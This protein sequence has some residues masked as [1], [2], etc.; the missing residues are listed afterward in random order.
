MDDFQS[1]ASIESYRKAY[2]R[3]TQKLHGS[4]G[5]VYVYEEDGVRTLKVGSRNRWLV[6]GD[7]NYGFCSFVESQREAF[8]KM[9]LGRHYGEW[10]GP[11]INSGE[12]LKGKSFYLFSNPGRYIEGIP[13]S[14]GFVPEIYLGPLDSS[15]IEA[16]MQLLKEHGSRLVPGFMKPEGI[17]VDVCGVKL[18]KVFEAEETGWCAKQDKPSR[19]RKDYSYL[20][21]PIRLE[22]L[23]SRDESYKRDYPK[24]LPNI[25]RAYIDDLVKEEQIVGSLDEVE[26]I[27]K[28]A[29]RQIFQFIK[30][31]IL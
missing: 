17:V 21:Q 13:E 8:L 12:G 15:K 3:I 26:K 23:M 28:N 27:R 31:S 14:V 18:K 30:Q 10:C 25:C 16:S 5:Q 19:E 29:S 4:N 2:M 11:G 20:C 9:G 6:I 24:S 1:F 7:D 22:K